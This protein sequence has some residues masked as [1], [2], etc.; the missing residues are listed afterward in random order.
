MLLE[1]NSVIPKPLQENIPAD[2]IWGKEL[3]FEPSE[4]YLIKA[5]SG[6]GKST[7]LSY[8]FGLR[9]DYTG[10]LKIGGIEAGKFGINEW[11]ELRASKI[12]IVFQNLRLFEDLTAMENIKIKQNVRPMYGEN[13]VFEMAEYLGVLGLMKK[14]VKHL[15]M[16]QQQRIALIRSLVQPFQWL[17]LDEPY[18]HL[19]ER[20]KGLMENLIDRYC[21]KNNAGLILTSLGED[22]SLIIKA[23]L[24]V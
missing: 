1:L 24:S 17:L 7:L 10:D 21:K 20:N 4:Y 9:N 18:S 2:S 6:R 16:G 19:D 12:S 14:K 11:S 15:S 3:V 22:S 23:E 13:E 8:L 5:A